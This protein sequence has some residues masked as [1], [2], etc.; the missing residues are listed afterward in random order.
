[1]KNDSSMIQSFD[2]SVLRIWENLSQTLKYKSEHKK[3]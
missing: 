3:N 1:M 2:F